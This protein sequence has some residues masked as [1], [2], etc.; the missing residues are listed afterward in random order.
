MPT[1]RVPI[2]RRR[3]PCRLSPAILRAFRKL[4]EAEDHEAWKAA[5]AELSHLIGDGKPWPYPCVVE[6]CTEWDGRTSRESYDQA[7]KNWDVLE[8]AFLESAT[9]REPTRPRRKSMNR[10]SSRLSAHK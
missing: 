3:T 4:Y 7:R 10:V 2:N 6:P 1:R 5:E 9:E 8:S